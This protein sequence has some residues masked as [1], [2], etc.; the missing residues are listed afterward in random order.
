MSG[1]NTPHP[2]TENELST[3]CSQARGGGEYAGFRKCDCGGVAFRNAG[4]G[5]W[6]CVACGLVMFRFRG[7]WVTMAEGEPEGPVY[8]C[9]FPSMRLTRIIVGRPPEKSESA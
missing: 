9:N 6:K 8:K 1:Q 4:S 3:P 7:V 2:E 5:R